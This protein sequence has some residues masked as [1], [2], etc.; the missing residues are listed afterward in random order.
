MPLNP[1]DSGS[2]ALPVDALL[3]A[4]CATIAKV[5]YCWAFTMSE[6]GMSAP[7]MGHVSHV[8]DEVE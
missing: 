2:Q 3:A 7:P 8:F 1:N 4:A 6:H 5:R